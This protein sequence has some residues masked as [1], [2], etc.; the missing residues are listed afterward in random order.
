MHSSVHS[1]AA[2]G[3]GNGLCGSSEQSQVR[4]CAVGGRLPCFV[5]CSTLQTSPV[6][7]PSDFCYQ[8][9]SE[10]PL[11]ACTNSRFPCHVMFFTVPALNCISM[12]RYFSVLQ[13]WLPLQRSAAPKHTTNIVACMP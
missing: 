13:G 4:C 5:F 12:S 3:V 11:L 8:Q 7:S 6:F 2:G 10:R 1:G 9:V